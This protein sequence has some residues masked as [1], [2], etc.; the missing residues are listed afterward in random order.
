[1]HIAVVGCGH[2]EIDKIYDVIAKIEEKQGIKVSAVL[3]CGDFQSVR[4]MTDLRC[5]ACPIK[6]QHMHDFHRYY[7]GEK[8]APVLTLFIGGN[9]EA[10]NF[11]QELPYGGWVAPNIFYMGYVGVVKVGPLRVAGISG[12]YKGHDYL[13]GRHEYPP[14]NQG[15]IRSVYHYRNL[16][17][18]RLKQIK[19][20][21]DIVLSHDWPKG[22]H[23]HGD[24]NRLLRQKPFFRDEI[25][26]NELGSRPLSEILEAIQPSYWF[27]AHMHVKFAAHISHSPPD[28][29]PTD[30][31]IEHSTSA[32]V[33]ADD[34][35]TNSSKSE[36][37]ASRATK[38]LA[39]D[40][41]LPRRQFLQIIEFPTSSNDEQVTFEYD[42]EW[43]AILKSTNNLVSVKDKPSFMPGPGYMPRSDFSATTEEMDEVLTL[44]EKD[45]SIKNNFQVTA[46]VFKPGEHPRQAKPCENP[47]TK[48]FCYK[49]GVVDPLSM[50]V[51][52]EM[53]NLS[54]S[55]LDEDY[56]EDVESQM[57]ITM[58]C[59]SRT[60]DSL[61]YNP[62]EISL[63][64]DDDQGESPS[65]LQQSEDNAR[66]SRS[67]L[68]LPPPKNGGD[69]SSLTT[70]EAKE[71]EGSRIF[72]RSTLVLPPPKHSENDEDN[73]EVRSDTKD[74]EA[75]STSLFFLDTGGEPEVKR[76]RDWMS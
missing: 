46:P 30:D 33:A 72:K 39:L 22:I 55:A 64:V 60:D 18:F 12:I 47:I 63:D 49:L 19:Q 9:H 31:E 43:L 76:R 75:E 50:L 70:G 61:N 1:M 10:S 62:D 44:F 14:Y 8:Q 6:Y 3:C 32:E 7:S 53:M 27:S 13:K 56:P 74:A 59:T 25:E 68:V 48:D 2:G 41:I 35:V 54:I 52:E 4:N 65:E 51:S 73:I 21:V 20:H 69:S 58:N 36:A 37:Q 38:F 40:K 42:A 29:R 17:I 28:N 5:M 26:R 34:V 45:L 11:L 24:F 66:L 71:Q 57:D 23:Q 16:D 15:T 67:K